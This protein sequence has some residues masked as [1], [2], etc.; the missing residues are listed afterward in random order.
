MSPICFIRVTEWGLEFPLVCYCWGSESTKKLCR[1]FPLPKCSRPPLAWC[2]HAAWGQAAVGR[3]VCESCEE[4]CW[5]AHA[6][7]GS[8]TSYPSSSLVLVCAMMQVPA[9]GGIDLPLLWWFPFLLWGGREV[10]GSMA[11]P[12]K[13]AGRLS[14]LS[15][16]STQGDAR[17][18]RCPRLPAGLATSSQ[19]LSHSQLCDPPAHLHHLTTQLN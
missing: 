10:V 5:G 16:R 15:W 1:L 9:P 17:P 6:L 8:C 13:G 18:G 14:W 3:A 19:S 4:P 11:V 12:L 2:S 7:L